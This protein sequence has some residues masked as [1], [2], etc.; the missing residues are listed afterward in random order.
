MKYVV[1]PKEGDP[2]LIDIYPLQHDIEGLEKKIDA[3]K[4]IRQV[5]QDTFGGGQPGDAEL[6]K[7]TIVE[8]AW[9]SAKSR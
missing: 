5:F 8:E 2:G 9:S 7:L 4:W 3:Q 6:A 1:N